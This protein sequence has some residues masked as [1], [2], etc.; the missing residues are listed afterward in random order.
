MTGLRGSLLPLRWHRAT[1]RVSGVEGTAAAADGSGSRSGVTVAAQL[2][3]RK[4]ESASAAPVP[5]GAAEE[6]AATQQAVQER[7][8]AEVDSA[9]RA[10]PG[11]RAKA[12]EERERRYVRCAG[13]GDGVRR[14][15]VSGADEAAAS[16]GAS[17]EAGGAVGVDGVASDKE[18]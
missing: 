10:S 12:G 13:G 15:G 3:P 16:G 14:S 11:R 2:L 8:T 6:E 4:R 1:G 18:T 9:A 5:A 7:G 17:T